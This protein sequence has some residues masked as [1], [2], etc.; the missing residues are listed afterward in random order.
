M[1]I[2]RPQL[3]IC[4]YIGWFTTFRCV[5]DVTIAPRIASTAANKLQWSNCSD[6]FRYTSYSSVVNCTPL[7]WKVECSI[8]S[9]WVNR[10]SAP[11][12]RAF[13]STALARSTIQASACRQ[14]PS[15][16]S[17]K[18]IIQ[19]QFFRVFQLFVPEVKHFH[20]KHTWKNSQIISNQSFCVNDFKREKLWQR[21]CFSTSAI[22]AMRPVR[23]RPQGPCSQGAPNM[24]N[25]CCPTCNAIYQGSAKSRLRPK[26]G[27]RG[28]PLGVT[29]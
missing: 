5:C 2:V 28:L 19:K 29:K 14:L 6:K 27:L 8:H 24:H 7:N 4:S 15:P 3:I 1:R 13:T 20:R 16:K 12:A 22:S 26:F 23:H 21:I 17:T 18:K 11:W 10:R 9:H 25:D